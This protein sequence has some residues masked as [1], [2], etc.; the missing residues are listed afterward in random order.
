MTRGR[1]SRCTNRASYVGH[2]M[3]LRSL[4][5]A[6]PV[7]DRRRYSEIRVAGLDLDTWFAGHRIRAIVRK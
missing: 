3:R 1:A 6:E 4:D 7:A 5:A 2:G